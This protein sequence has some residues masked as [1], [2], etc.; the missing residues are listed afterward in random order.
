MRVSSMATHGEVNP[1]A[2]GC[3]GGGG[4]RG[5]P[6]SARGHKRKGMFGNIVKKSFVPQGPLSAEQGSI[7]GRFHIH[8]GL[9]WG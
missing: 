7:C 8:V 1:A 5:S 2:V 3:P 9:T 6:L 4:G